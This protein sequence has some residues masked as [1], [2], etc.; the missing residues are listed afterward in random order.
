MSN[1]D[2]PRIR[3]H[4]LLP[5]PLV[6]MGIAAALSDHSA[7]E[8]ACGPF[9]EDVTELPCGS[10]VLADY[11]RGLQLALAFSRRTKNSSGQAPC[12]L[13]MT[14][15]DREHSVRLA[16]ELGVR[17]YLPVDCSLQELTDAVIALS[18]GSR[19]LSSAAAARMAESLGR[20]TLTLRETEVLRLVA[21]GRC[22][23][24]I[25]RQL[26]IAIGTVKAHVKS[27]LAKLEASSRTQAVA[28]ASQRGLIEVAAME[29]NERELQRIT[30]TIRE[31]SRRSRPM[32]A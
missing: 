24:S 25:A 27:I 13:V 8:V 32:F 5:E 17:G 2:T 6:A 22:N 10:V 18:R 26:D 9:D 30:P 31:T 28:V 15:N 19:Y 12:V 11:Q 21:S 23:K 20:E 14:R 16:L 3:F 4:V 1:T 29:N 7:I